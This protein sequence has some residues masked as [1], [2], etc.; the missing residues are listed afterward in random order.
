MKTIAAM[1]EHCSNCLSVACCQLH[2]A[3]GAELA[4]LTQEA[5]A[6][7]WCNTC[8]N[9]NISN[10]QLTYHICLLQ[11]ALQVEVAVQNDGSG[12]PQI[13]SVGHVSMHFEDVDVQ[14]FGAKLAWLYNIVLR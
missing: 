6:P 9:A 8:F 10:P 14:T 12:H 13:A 2:T 4:L 3:Q 11:G 1:K 5:V 7:T